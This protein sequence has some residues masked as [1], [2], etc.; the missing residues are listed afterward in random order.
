VE[1]KSK[2]ENSQ[3]FSKYIGKNTESG[4]IYATPV[5]VKINDVLLLQFKKL[6][7]DG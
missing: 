2:V 7:S 5:S 3:S 4:N 1:W 6:I